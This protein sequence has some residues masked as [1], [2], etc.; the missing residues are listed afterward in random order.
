V[1]IT[2][3]SDEAWESLKEGAE[4]AWAS[5]KA[6]FNEAASKFKE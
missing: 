2:G 1:K 3:V 6:G 5:L 4:S